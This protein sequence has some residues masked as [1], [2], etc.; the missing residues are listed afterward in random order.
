MRFRIEHAYNVVMQL[1]LFEEAR[2]RAPDLPDDALVEEISDSVI[3]DLDE[4]P[5]VNLRVVAAS[6]GI[7]R[8]RVSDIPTA[9]ALSR[10][11]NGF[12]IRLRRGDS[13]SRQRFTGF[14]EVAHTFQ[15]GYALKTQ[16]R[17]PSPSPRPRRSL[18]LEALCDISAAELLMPARFFSADL[19]RGSFDAATLLDLADSYEASLEAT[20]YR[21]ARFFPSDGVF[22]VL[23]PGL[24]KAERDNPAA[25]PKLR[26]RSRSTARSLPFLPLNKSV[27]D[28]GILI[29]AQHEEVDAV[30]TLS[31]I[32]IDSEMRIRISAIPAPYRNAHGEVRER[33]LALVRPLQFAPAKMAA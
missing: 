13:R 19:Q 9:G 24:R 1:S 6:R 2:A 8:I 30:T 12:V 7:D 3:A 33:V 32:G 5:P 11:D 16:F 21:M 25:I 20:G 31:A 17:C 14:H 26:I 18:D 10:D 28:D 22:V 15:P 29:Q 23:E 27:A 4:R